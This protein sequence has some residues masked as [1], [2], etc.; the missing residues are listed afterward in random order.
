MLPVKEATPHFALH[1]S[2]SAKTHSSRAFRL[3]EG[4]P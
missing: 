4:G 1:A 3:C 2:T